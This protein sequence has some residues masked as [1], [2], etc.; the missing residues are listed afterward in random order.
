[1][2]SSSRHDEEGATVVLTPAEVDRELAARRGWRRIGDALVRELMFRDFE[3]ALGFV[4]R[5]A[6][7]A[8]DYKRRPDMCISEF[9]RVRLTID[10]P[11]HAGLTLAEVRLV[12]KVDHAIAD[13]GGPSS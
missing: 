2:G 4:E 10:N 7:A 13:A 8:V 11:H 12:D 6:Q 9:N 3:E 1:M 5:V